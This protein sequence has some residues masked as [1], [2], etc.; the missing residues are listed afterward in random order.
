MRSWISDPNVRVEGTC[1]CGDN[2]G[3][4]A[5]QEMNEVLNDG[6]DNHRH[7]DD[8][9]RGSKSHVGN[10]KLYTKNCVL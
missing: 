3:K 4:T 8:Y 2:R 5:G 1:G 6:S 10:S 7:I 9:E